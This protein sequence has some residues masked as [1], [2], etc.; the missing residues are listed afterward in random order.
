[1]DMNQR[2][3]RLWMWAAVAAA[4]W[5]AGPAARACE[6]PVYQYALERWPADAYPAMVFYRGK[7]DA[8]AAKVVRPANAPGNALAPKP[9]QVL[10]ELLE[11]A[12]RE[13]CNLYV[14]TVDVDQP[15]AAAVQEV[16]DRHK[17][18]ALGAVPKGTPLPHMVVLYPERSYAEGEL[19][20]GPVE[21]AKIQAMSDSPARRTIAQAI[22]QQRQVAVWVLLESGNKQAD[23]EAARTL[24]AALKAAPAELREAGL[25]TPASQPATQ[26]TTQPATQAADPAEPPMAAPPR[27]PLPA[28]LFSTLR[29]S[30]ADPQEQV[31]IRVLSSVDRDLATKEAVAQPIVIPI[32]ARGR[33]LGALVGPMIRKENILHA[34]GLLA[35]PCACEIKYQNPGVDLLFTADW[36]SAVEPPFVDDL[37]AGPLAQGWQGRGKDP[38]TVPPA[39]GGGTA[40]PFAAVGP[41]PNDHGRGKESAIVPP[42]G[43]FGLI[44]MFAAGGLGAVVVIVAVAAVIIRRK[45]RTA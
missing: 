13:Q 12:E 14:A 20:S 9:A 37:P 23:D 26:P 34:C 27:R 44:W 3:R 33:A 6:T 40:A 22:I 8:A 45:G 35:G 15:M 24:E 21:A 1:M 32:F 43:G 29:L 28:V 39:G 7:L 4:C 42:D 11:A 17:Q 10:A 38:A 2:W 41:G 5:P 18:A 19:W 36:P 25:L 31:F 30:R 16:W